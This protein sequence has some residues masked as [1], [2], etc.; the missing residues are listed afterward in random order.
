MTYKDFKLVATNPQTVKREG[1]K[2]VTFQVQVV[3]SPVGERIAGVDAQYDAMRLRELLG[4]IEGGDADWTQAMQLGLFLAGALLPGSVHDLLVRSI[5]IA[6]TEGN[7]L[8][9]RLMLDGELHN[10][11]WEY[12]LL[13]RAGGEVSRT[14]FLTL[15]PSTSIVRH[16]PAEIPAKPIEASLPAQMVAALSSPEKWPRLQVDKERSVIAEA[17]SGNEHIQVTW[18]HP[19][20]KDTLWS[21][22]A[23]AHLFHFAGHGGFP[24][25][26]SGKPGKV[27]GQGLLVLQDEYGDPEEV[28]ADELAN[29]LRE[30]GVRV[31][32]LGACESGRRDDVNVWSSV[33]AS[34]TK[35]GLGA[36]VG[37]QF[38]ILDT[39]A[40]NFATE[41]YRALV[42]GLTIDEAVSNGRIKVAEKDTCGWGTPVLYLR[43]EDGLVFPEYTADPSLEPLRERILIEGEEY[44]TTLRGEATT[45]YIDDLLEG[46]VKGKAVIDTVAKG[47]KHT[48]VRIKRVG[49]GSVEANSEA[50]EVKGNMTGVSID[51][52]GG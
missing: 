11:P 24:T 23:Q 26:I 31:A 32:V 41:F 45:V 40:K 21:G 25:E 50:G 42:A 20:G 46:D 18:K 3:H 34:L 37:M 49:G 51:S 4:P 47:G 33:A 19:A 5:D 43:S 10:V 12:L 52:L 44:I 27:A 38:R 9:L 17:L 14:D 36:V 7:R 29:R 35:V 13:N 15:S 22:V 1:Q 6:E 39:S 30:K 28:E 16:Q 2:L 8:R 48:T